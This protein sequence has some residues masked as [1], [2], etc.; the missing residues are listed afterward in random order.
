MSL[1]NS[2]CREQCAHHKCTAQWI[3]TNWHNC[4]TRIHIMKLNIFFFFFFFFFCF[5]GP[6]SQYVEVPRLGD[7]LE[8]QLP[9]DS[10]ATATWDLSHSATYTT[11][12]GNARSPTHWARP[13]IEPM[14]S[15]I[16]VGFVSATPQQ[17]LPILISNTNKGTTS[18]LL[19]RASFTK[20]HVYK[21]NYC[22]KLQCY[23]SLSLLYNIPLCD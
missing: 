21:I 3:F 11:A 16:L 20:L 19:L 23:P 17:E 10:M 15:W 18:T 1:D 6:H 8:L 22:C 13:G 4:G 5:L 14:S 9:A 7:E 2:I 12:Y